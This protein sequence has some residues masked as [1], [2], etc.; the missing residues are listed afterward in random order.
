MS[1]ECSKAL[2]DRLRLRSSSDSILRDQLNRIER[3]LHLVYPYSFFYDTKGNPNYNLKSVIL[4]DY[5]SD[6]TIVRKY[7]RASFLNDL[8]VKYRSSSDSELIFYNNELQGF[9]LYNPYLSINDQKILWTKQD[10]EFVK[11]WL[12][13]GDEIKS[14]SRF[15]FDECMRIVNADY[16]RR[17]RL[18]KR[19]SQIIDTNSAYFITLTF[20]DETLNKTS[21]SVRR[22]Y[23]SRFLKS[24]SDYFVGNIDFG[25]LK[26]REHYH[27]VICSKVLD[28]AT[29]KFSKRYGYICSS[30]SAFDPW[31]KYGFYSIKKCCNT[32][33][34]RKK[35][36]CYVNKLV[37][38]AI[39]ET[40]KRNALL[41]SR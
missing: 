30:C 12:P 17:R 27:A 33:I 16:Q 3:S 29:F 31:S 32:E 22:I 11:K 19:I 9:Y 6:L 4:N 8:I 34:D 18:K 28:D 40:T 41:Y 5:I 14:K 36:S 15:L 10:E 20:S 26:G 38:H 24:I 35:L 37:S 7:K 1:F 2:F 25:K 21:A 39:K 23:V 13:L